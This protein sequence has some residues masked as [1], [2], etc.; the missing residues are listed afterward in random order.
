MKPAKLFVIGLVALVTSGA[1]MA[2][3]QSAIGTIAAVQG[4]IE[5]QRGKSWVA[6]A[7]GDEIGPG[8]QLRTAPSARA[9][10]LLRDESVID[11][12]SASELTI[13]SI[14]SPPVRRPSVL[15]LA[16][17]KL[18]AWVS[19]HYREARARF[20]VE[21]PT[22]VVGVRGT[23]MIVI[24]SPDTELTEVVGIQEQVEVFGKLAVPSSSVLVG[25]SG[26]TQVQ[27]G[28]FPTA[29]QSIDEMRLRQFHEGLELRGTGRR[30]GLN[31]EHSLLAGRL[32]A[33]EDVPAT[34]VATQEPLPAAL[35]SR[36][37]QPPLAL[38]YS[39]DVY[40]NRQPLRQ[41]RLVPPGNRVGSGGGTGG[42]VVDF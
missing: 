12:G 29:T 13:E 37:G 6:L 8:A 9:K 40:T 24:Y 16:K 41:Y 23:E 1:P 14:D 18:H 21:T 17:G 31:V 4:T 36:P 26:Y 30:D 19:D 2:Y 22:A 20:E 25:A 35:E 38:R 7:T 39:G 5:V 33:A 28:R 32:L 11:L 34:A 27:K 3:S 42:V 15:R 10:L